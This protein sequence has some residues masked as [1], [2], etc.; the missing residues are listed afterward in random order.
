MAKNKK[1]IYVKHCGNCGRTFETTSS[2]LMYCCRECYQ[3][4]NR[5]KAR[6]RQRRLKKEQ[7]GKD[8]R[9]R[10]QPERK[11]RTVC[12][13]KSTCIYGRRFNSSGVWFCDFATI[14]GHP[15]GCAPSECTYYVPR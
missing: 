3:N 12:D 6:E 5:K 1:T 14:T 15:R 7:T 13:R 10:I 11:T 8:V 4:A 9:V 2:R